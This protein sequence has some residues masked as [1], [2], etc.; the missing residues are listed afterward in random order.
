MAGLQSGDAHRYRGVPCRYR[1][2]AGCVPASTQ[3][4]YKSLEQAKT[5]L[6]LMLGQFGLDALDSEASLTLASEQLNS[7]SESDFLQ[8]EDC[9][10][11]DSIFRKS[12]AHVAG[13]AASA[14]P[15]GSQA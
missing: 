14:V 1:Y 9:A 5:S 15:F 3:C 10:A 2:A 12:P 6:T 13:Q 11:F 8:L 7:I 4:S